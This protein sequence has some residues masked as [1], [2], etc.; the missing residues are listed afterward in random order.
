M[1]E[2]AVTA[3]LLDWDFTLAYSIAPNIS[4][5]ERLAVLFQTYGIQTTTQQITRVLQT[6]HQDI[7]NGNEKGTL[8]PQKRSQIIYKYRQILTRLGHHD[9]SYD[10]AYHVYSGYA[11]LPHFLYA[12]VEETLQRLKEQEIKIGIL[13]NHSRSARPVMEKMLGDFVLPA[14]IT[15]SEEIGSHK[16]A[17]STFQKAASRLKTAVT[18]CMMV[19]D[20]LAVDATGAVKNGDFALGVWIDRK[21][22]GSKFPL[23]KKVIRITKLTELLPLIC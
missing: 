5:S 23:P 17:K 22:V 11:K 15:L 8:Y 18:H 3:V 2:K 4:Q 1:A 21:N 7:A 9:T 20:N 10:F 16:P 14:N 19:G 13:S 12:D 6:L